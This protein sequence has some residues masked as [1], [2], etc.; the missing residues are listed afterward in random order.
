M[1]KSG[2]IRDRLEEDSNPFSLKSFSPIE[3]KDS[4]TH[5]HEWLIEDLDDSWDMYCSWC[6][7]WKDWSKE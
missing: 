7:Q 4:P 1:T 6:Y 2:V 5:Q 3:C